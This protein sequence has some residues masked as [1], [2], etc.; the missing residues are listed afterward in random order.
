MMNATLLKPVSSFHAG[1]V[2]PTEYVRPHVA[3]KFLYTGDHKFYLRGVTYGP[4][5][6]DEADCEYHTPSA[7]NRD[8]TLMAENG[9]NA[10]RTYTVPPRWLLD[11][12]C[13]HGLRVMVGIPW[14]QHITFLDDR[15]RVRS[16]RQRVRE[17]VRACANHPAVFC[18]VIG[19]EIPAPIVRW[20]GRRRVE[21]FI[22]RLYRSAKDEDPGALVTYVNYPTTEYL[23]LPFLDF[24]CFNVYLESRDSL[25]RYLARL[26]N[27]AGNHPLVMA[28]IGLDSR[29]NGEEEQA[30]SLRWQLETASEA[31]CAGAFVFS[32][33]DEWHRGGYDIE[34]W[35]FGLTT[36]DR[37]AKPAL[38]S[39]REAFSWIPAGPQVEW[40]R[41]SV[42]VCAYNEEEHI[43]SCLD[44][45]SRLD[46]PDFEVLVVDDGSTDATY[47]IASEYDFNLIRTE[48]QG[49]S[50]ARNTGMEAATGSIVAYI[51]ADAYPDPHWLIHLAL[52]FLKTDHAAIGGPNIVPPKLGQVAE[53]VGRA[54]GGPVH[55][56]LTDEEAEHIP[57]CNMAFFKSALEEVGGFDPQFRI[58]GDDVNVCWKLQQRGWTLGFNPAAMVWHHPRGSLRHYW[59]QQL[60][61]GRAEALLE[62]EWP[63][64]YNHH[65]HLTWRGRVYG[66]S[67]TRPLPLR[68]SRIYHGVW[69][70]GLFQRL[71]APSNGKLLSLPLMPEWFLVIL[72]LA[73]LSS[74]GFLWKPLLLVWPLLLLAVGAVL[75]QSVVSAMRVSFNGSDRSRPLV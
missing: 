45:L 70:T 44:G 67:H 48:N 51:D 23:E 39:A 30:S 64:K 59:R 73:G 47:A 31:G 12:A 21:R 60:N 32:W 1:E 28:E 55:V 72:G 50:N 46:Y 75:V 71:Y 37:S 17:S 57:G 9:I 65:G 74:L 56:L 36:R 52:S 4:F 24:V 10:V 66:D 49:L 58:A 2:G 63:E 54:P 6:P 14:E 29:R 16:I 26:Q 43:R 40:P 5:R 61:Y 53:C 22:H 62:R 27:L 25:A 18:Y 33:T 20:Q 15:R 3:G 8:F 13:S 42:V 11:E 7:V 19:N 41:I 35:D 68:R 34:D 69:G 38:E